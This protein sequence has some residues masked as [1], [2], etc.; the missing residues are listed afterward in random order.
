MAWR[1]RHRRSYE[2]ATLLGLWAV[3][4]VVS[5]Q[6]HFWRFLAVWALYSGVTAFHLWCCAFRK[7]DKTTPKRVSGVRCGVWVD[8]CV[9]VRGGVRG[10]VGGCCA[11]R[12]ES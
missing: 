12:N 9:C 3:P 7:M 5:V 2:L 8:V 11:L 10:C 6:L 4:A 1:Q